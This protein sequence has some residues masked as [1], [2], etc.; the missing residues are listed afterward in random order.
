MR[1]K[2]LGV[3]LLLQ[4]A[5]GL[6]ALH[7]ILPLGTATPTIEC[8]DETDVETGGTTERCYA[9]EPHVMELDY[10][11]GL[12]G[13]MVAGSAIVMF[14]LTPWSVFEYAGVLRH[15]PV[16]PGIA[17]I[18]GVVLFIAAALVV[19]TDEATARFSV[20]TAAAGFLVLIAAKHWPDAKAQE[21]NTPPGP[22]VNPTPTE[23]DTPAVFQ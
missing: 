20:I 3:Y 1:W 2:L 7:F 5:V 10:P 18:V 15:R 22:P 9:I 19:W 21:Q 4:T 23:P 17:W 8:Y 16:V 13:Y 11:F 6:L 14:F 12:V